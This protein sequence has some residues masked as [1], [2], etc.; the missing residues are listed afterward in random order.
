MMRPEKKK[1]GFPLRVE[2]EEAG[3]VD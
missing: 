2:N 3:I 1:G